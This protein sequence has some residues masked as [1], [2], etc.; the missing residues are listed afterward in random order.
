MKSPLAPH[1]PAT[2]TPATPA[3]IFSEG[4][5]AGRGGVIFA[6]VAPGALVNQCVYS[7]VALSASSTGAGEATV[8]VGATVPALDAPAARTALGGAVRAGPPADRATSRPAGE[9]GW[10]KSSVIHHLPSR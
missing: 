1:M 10:R 8:L 4:D 5:V 6:G 9:A 2:A 7:G 3:G